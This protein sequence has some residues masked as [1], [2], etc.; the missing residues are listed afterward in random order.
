MAQL[1]QTDPNAQSNKYTGP[2]S[3]PAEAQR[4]GTLALRPLSNA[5]QRA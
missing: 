1:E 4:M 5:A 3:G 2:D